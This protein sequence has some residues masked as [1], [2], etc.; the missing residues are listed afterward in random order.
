LATT[1]LGII[2]EV[3]NQLYLAAK[4]YGRVLELVGDPPRPVACE[5]YF[6][7]ARL[8]Y[9]WNDVDAAQEYGQQ[10][11]QLARQIENIDS[12][13]AGEVFLARLKLAQGDVA[14]AAAILTKKLF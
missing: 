13:V 12:F 3:E 10:S 8:S 6:G 5:A 2:Q 9:Q 14:G 1:G 7:L 11:V 4:T